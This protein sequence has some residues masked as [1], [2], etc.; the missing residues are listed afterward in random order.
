MPYQHLSGDLGIDGVDIVEEARRE[1]A[2]DLKNQPGKKDDGK[3]TTIPAAG[4]R[5]K[6]L[7]GCRRRLNLGNGVCVSSNELGNP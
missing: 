2:A 4:R 1:K 3:R 7:G 5:R 6:S